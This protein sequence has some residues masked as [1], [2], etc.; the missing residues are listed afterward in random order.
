MI[1]ARGFVLGNAPWNFLEARNNLITKCPKHIAGIF[2]LPQGCWRQDINTKERIWWTFSTAK[3]LPR[4]MVNPSLFYLTATQNQIER[5]RDWFSIE[6]WTRIIEKTDTGWTNNKVRLLGR[7][8]FHDHLVHPAFSFLCCTS[9]AVCCNCKYSHHPT[10]SMDWH[11]F[12]SS[13]WNDIRD[14]LILKFHKHLFLGT[15]KDHFLTIKEI[16]FILPRLCPRLRCN[17]VRGHYSSL[18]QQQHST[19]CPRSQ[20]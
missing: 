6:C 10:P 14:D 8:F 16:F 1:V 4:Q 3:F 7:I 15:D 20:A 17:P 19:F 5:N 11:V 12:S 2:Q 13:Y 18:T 9:C